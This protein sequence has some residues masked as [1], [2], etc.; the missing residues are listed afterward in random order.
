M[1]QKR[2]AI[3]STHPIQYNAPLFRLI[4][5]SDVCFSI[6]VFYT[7]SQSQQEVFDK[8]FGVAVKWDIPLL[9]GYDYTFVANTSSAPGSHH[10]NGIVNS[11]LNKE[12]EDWK[13]DAVL[14]YGWAFSGHLKA[15]RYFHKRIPVLFRG[16]STLL[17]EPAGFSVKKFLRRTSLKWIYSHIDYALYV[18]TANQNYFLA[19]GLKRN[20]LLFA[21]HAIDNN[22][23]A[24]QADEYEIASKKWRTDLGIS[25]KE[26]VFLFAA[27]LTKKKNSELLIKAFLA[28]ETKATL[29]IVGNGE[30]ETELKEK[31]KTYPNI[32]FIGF[33]NQSLMPVVYRLG[34]VFVLPSQGP[35]ETW[36]LAVNEAMACGRA[37][38]ASDKCGCS[39]D[40]ISTGKNGYVF[41]SGDLACLQKC[42]Q[43]SLKNYKHAGLYSQQIIQNWNYQKTIDQLQAVLS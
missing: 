22:R 28:L 8:E 7:W 15:I 9:E 1:K 10:F 14:I 35:G 25:A 41:E 18:G 4:H 39:T 20:Q 11:S 38:I 16:D 5:E 37:V 19:N 43:A 6:K 30:L 26:S 21:P 24:D 13:A 31:Y 29:L 27:K 40:L 2:L 32:I 34:N 3:I 12:I 23:F 17:D 42:M 36:G 33:Q